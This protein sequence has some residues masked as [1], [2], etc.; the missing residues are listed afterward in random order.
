MKKAHFIG[1]CGTGMSAV[2]MLLVEQGW[3]VTGSDEGFYPP[4]SDYLKESG[5]PCAAGYAAENIPAGA[6]MIVIGK[7]AKLVPES[8]EEVRAAFASGIPI[9]SFPEVLQQLTSG[10]KNY[11][12][13]GSFGKSTC[14]SIAGWTLM[15]AGKDPSY[16]IGAIS[17]NLPTSSRTGRGDAF[18][19]EGDEYPSANWDDTSKFLYYNAHTVLLT[20]CAHDHVNVF[21]T[22]ED[23]LQ[24][25]I[26]LLR[27]LPANGLLVACADGEN[28]ADVLRRAGREAT[29][30]SL[31]PGK[32]DWWAE[33]IT[34]GD[35][36]RFRL[37]HRGF[38]VARLESVLLG[39]HNVQNMVGVAAFLLGNQAVTP[40]E[41]GAAFRAFTGV[42]RRL[43]LKT[44]N[45]QVRVYE[46]FGSS[47]DKALAGLQAMAAQF[48]GRRMLVVFE[49]HTFSFR[50]RSALGWYDDL[51]ALAD[52]VFVYQPPT[53]GAGTHEQLTHQEIVEAIRRSGKP[54]EGVTSTEDL[55]AHLD[56]ILDPADV[57]LLITSGDLGG[58]I[59]AVAELAN[60]R[61]P[62][63]RT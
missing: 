52:R 38:E 33:E 28:V 51:F 63:N 49:P 39:D 12:V 6:D 7:H 8:N 54:A 40:E 60:S 48:P 3:E 26:R 17:Y 1:I 16:F 2:A 61:F 34:R 55:L 9:R 25:Y 4:I 23:Y 36:T 5:I 53:H 20:S 57:V 62:V 47:R 27:G 59:G 41:L 14:S 15:H 22:L 19:L 45:S 30:Y 35:L 43:E 42:R 24:P 11:V 50:N 31:H 18:I 29:T 46:D 44:P 32:A 10:T 21:P 37:I 58:S 13:T 56:P